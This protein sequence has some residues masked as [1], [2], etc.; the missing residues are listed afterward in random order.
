MAIGAIAVSFQRVRA[1]QS[2]PARVVVASVL[3][4]AVSVAFGALIGGSIALLIRGV[5][6][7]YVARKR[8]EL[9]A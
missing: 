3:L 6:R 7:M 5:R 2:T 8:S 1:H 4:E 9:A